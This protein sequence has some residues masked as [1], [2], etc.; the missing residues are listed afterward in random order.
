MDSSSDPANNFTLPIVFVVMQNV[1]AENCTVTNSVTMHQKGSHGNLQWETSVSSSSFGQQSSSQ[2]QSNADDGF[3][4]QNQQQQ[5]G[6]GFG[7]GNN[8]NK[9]WTTFAPMKKFNT[10]F[11]TMKPFGQFQK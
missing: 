3:Q 7:Q 5:N 10:I 8:N 11:P 9:S 1:A 2:S 6:H 4:N